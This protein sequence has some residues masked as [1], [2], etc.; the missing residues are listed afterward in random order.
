MIHFQ[1]P[2]S[3]LFRDSSV[4]ETEGFHGT[5]KEHRIFLVQSLLEGSKGWC[6]STTP[7]QSYLQPP[8][9]KRGGA[10]WKYWFQLECQGFI[11]SKIKR[12]NV[13][14]KRSLPKYSQSYARSSR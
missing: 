8:R 4:H 14:I 7:P 3:Q 9:F 12:F 2:H 1:H 6:S 5:E 10:E 11:W 13:D